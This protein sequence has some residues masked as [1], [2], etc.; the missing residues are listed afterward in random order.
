VRT[1]TLST[2]FYAPSI[3]PTD[4]DQLRRYVEDELRKV[5]AAIALLASGYIEKT[6]VAPSKPRE[7][8]VRL[9]DGTNWNPG[10]GAGVYAYYNGG[11]HFLG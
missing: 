8:D 7:G 4:S 10:S 9:A 6:T 1:P 2:V 5:A 11:W 3:A